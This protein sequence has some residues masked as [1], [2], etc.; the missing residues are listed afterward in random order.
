MYSSFRGWLHRVDQLHIVQYTV[1]LLVATTSVNW[2][3]HISVSYR[4]THCNDAGHVRLNPTYYEVL[5][6][7]GI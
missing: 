3:A 7:G 5:L 6:V 4:V 1:R 2:A